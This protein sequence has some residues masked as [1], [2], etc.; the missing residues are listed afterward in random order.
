MMLWS[1]QST[2]MYIISFDPYNIVCSFL[3]LFSECLLWNDV[4]YPVPGARN[5]TGNKKD[6]IIALVELV[7]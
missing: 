3:Q 1:F 5:I 7:F 2:F 6:K 4:S